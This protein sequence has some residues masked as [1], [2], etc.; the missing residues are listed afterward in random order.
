MGVAKAAI[1]DKDSTLYAHVMNSE[2]A[3]YYDMNHLAPSRTAHEITLEIRQKLLP[4]GH[5][6]IANA[7]GN[8]GN[9]ESAEGNYTTALD[10]LERAAEIRTKLGGEGSVYLALTYM[11]IGRV[12]ALQNKDADAYQMIQ[13]SESILNRR[14]G[15]NRLFI[16][17]IHYE[18]GNLELKQGEYEQAALSFEKCRN[19]ARAQGPLL[20]MTASANYKL[21]VV[22]FA[23]GHHKKALNYLIKAQ[24]IA[25]ARNPGD[26]DGGVT[27]VHWKIAEVLLDDPLGDRREEGLKLKHDAESR[28]QTLVDKLGINMRGLDETH[29]AEK[30][31]D[32]LVPGYFR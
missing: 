26:L 18:F 17:A 15:R 20:P 28:R 5:A 14:G 7:L 30:A 32:M 6:E 11:Q 8:L 19:L 3:A 25:E 31:F 21:G 13:K 1:Y 10:Y 23:M 22:E 4:A 16:A 29:D 12:Y 24:D 2:G 27:R 9:V